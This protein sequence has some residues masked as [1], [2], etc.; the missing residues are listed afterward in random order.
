MTRKTVRSYMAAAAILAS[1]LLVPTLGRAQTAQTKG[2]VVEEIVARVN[3]EIVTLSDLDKARESLR[4]DVQQ[5]CPGC[6]QDRFDAL[7]K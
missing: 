2:K 6:P 5:D 1:A 3:N 7:Y 4:E